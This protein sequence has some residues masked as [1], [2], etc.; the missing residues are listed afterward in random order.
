MTTR[1][2]TAGLLGLLGATMLSA[3]GVA[4]T[5][6]PPPTAAQAQAAD[7]RQGQFVTVN[8]TNIFYQDSGGSDTP[9]LLIHGF[10]L[11]GQLFQGQ[12]SGLASQFRVITPD[13][14]GFGKSSIPNAQGAIV[15]YAQDILALM[16]HLNIQK[17]VIGGH[18]MG[19]QITME[20]YKEAPARFLG[21]ILIDTNFMPAS[22]VEKAQWPAFGVQA[23][24]LG[25]PSIVPIIT[26]QMITGLE[27]LINVPATTTMMDML[28]EGS[29]NGVIGGGQALSTRPDY[30]TLLPTVA[31]PAL[32]LVGL[33]D[34]IYSTEISEMMKAAIPNAQL[35][36]IPSAE[37]GSIFEQ[38]GYANF[39]IAQWAAQLP[40]K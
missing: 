14:R 12:Y 11:T 2:L 40:S 31:V 24:Q 32:V 33:D 1:I 23:T 17:A 6:L 20:L 37:H 21:M 25:V 3:E 10:P 36:I 30:T 39:L 29:L 8:G 35:G 18:S 13:L 38:P 27:R 5:P 34:P 15:T 26:P 16:D 4:Q 9:I 7:T 28:A 19:G 22:V